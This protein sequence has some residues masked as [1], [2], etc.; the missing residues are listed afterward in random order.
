[1]EKS[2]EGMWVR[3]SCCW[4]C[5]CCLR[6][7]AA[8]SSSSVSLLLPDQNCSSAFLSSRL[9]PI[10]GYPRLLACTIDPSFHC[11]LDTFMKPPFLR[12]VKDAK[13]MQ[14]SELLTINSS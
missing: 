11:S 9:L 2:L 4:S 12:D 14:Q 10:R 6:R 1:M 7:V 8:C 5:Q 13:G 3:P